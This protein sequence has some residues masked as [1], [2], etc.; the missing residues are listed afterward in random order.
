MQT[1]VLTLQKAAVLLKAQVQTP[2]LSPRYYTV[3]VTNPAV[4][5]RASFMAQRGRE[6]SP[7]AWLVIVHSKVSK[8]IIVLLRTV[9]A[10]LRP[11]FGH[12]QRRYRL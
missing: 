10:A 4:L 12:E 9:A 6:R 1:I 3:K 7:C 11:T 5:C 2:D 8:G